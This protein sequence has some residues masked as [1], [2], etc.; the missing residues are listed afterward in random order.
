M[1][2]TVGKYEGGEV[3]PEGKDFILEGKPNGFASILS[4]NLKLRFNKHKG[5]RYTLVTYCRPKGNTQPG[6]KETVAPAAG[7][8]SK[9]RRKFF[10]ICCGKES[11]LGKLAPDDCEVIR[12]TDQEDFTKDETVN[13]VVKGITSP[14]DTAWGSLPCVG[15]SSF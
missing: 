14:D 5:T 9:R 8:T 7:K 15:G 12:I 11:L 2:M 6:K 10:D 3:T 13:R 4:S 1:V